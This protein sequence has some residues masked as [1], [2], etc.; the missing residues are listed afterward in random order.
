MGHVTDI[1]AGSARACIAARLAALGRPTDF[2]T[3][4]AIEALVAHAGDSLPRLRAALASTLFLGSTE[5]ALRV[6]RT[7]VERAVASLPPAG[8][9]QH[10]RLHSVWLLAG[11]AAA[12]VA[13]GVPVAVWHADTF[14]TGEAAPVARAAPAIPASLAAAQPPQPAVTAP[15][16]SQPITVRNPP[17]PPGARPLTAASST[18]I[19]APPV[20]V[21]RYQ[22]SAPAAEAQLAFAA[23]ALRH[24]GFPRVYAYPLRGRA[25][26]IGVRYF[27]PGDQAAAQRL[28]A[29]AAG[30]LGENPWLHRRTELLLVPQSA[31]KP[32]HPPGTLELILP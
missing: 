22:P 18:A 26:P 25:T 30:P 3:E 6:D 31:A 8:P 19:P 2:L 23:A 7:Y 32:A 9:R 17:L 13:I 11:V 1:R 24:A 12:S 21:L 20:V 5:E 4:D 14:A 16:L 10:R 15:P 28:L 27:Y 29:I